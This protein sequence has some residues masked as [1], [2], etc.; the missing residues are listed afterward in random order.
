MLNRTGVAAIVFALVAAGLGFAMY[1]V[2]SW[3]T[4]GEAT[5]NIERSCDW[6]PSEDVRKC[7]ELEG[8]Y[9][10]DYHE[11]NLCQTRVPTNSQVQPGLTLSHIQHKCSRRLS[12]HLGKLMEKYND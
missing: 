12:K 4:H 8:R 7:Y 5:I 9:S 1:F 11:Y 6:V 2:E 3:I 10:E